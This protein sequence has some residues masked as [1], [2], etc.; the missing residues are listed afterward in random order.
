[1]AKTGE[2]KDE[3]DGAAEEPST[4]TPTDRKKYE[5]LYRCYGLVVS[6]VMKGG[7]CFTLPFSY[8]LPSPSA[9]VS[10]IVKEE[11]YGNFLKEF[12]N[13]DETPQQTAFGT[14]SSRDEGGNKQTSAPQNGGTGAPPSDHIV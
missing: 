2:D 10:A 5:I 12:E 6:K 3:G 11:Q 4:A 8:K 9:V 14:A 13:F 7:S 1:M